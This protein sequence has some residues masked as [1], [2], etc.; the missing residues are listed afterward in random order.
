M[1]GGK[2]CRVCLVSKKDAKLKSL[3]KING[4]KALFF[5]KQFGINVRSV[6]SQ[7]RKNEHKFIPDC[8]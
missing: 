4:R 1:T 8:S 5:E 3:H 2:R 7:I 6:L